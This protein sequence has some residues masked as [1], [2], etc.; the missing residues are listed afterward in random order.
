[1]AWICGKE[2]NPFQIT[3]SMCDLPTKTYGT[4]SHLQHCLSYMNLNLHLGRE[5]VEHTNSPVAGR[6]DMTNGLQYYQNLPK[7][8]VY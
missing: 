3:S 8:Q 1:M 2:L 6:A 7:C 5:S 4:K